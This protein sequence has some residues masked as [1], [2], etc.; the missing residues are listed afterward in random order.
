MLRTE[1]RNGGFQ[2]TLQVDEQF[3]LLP[4]H[5]PGNPILPGMCMVQAVLL[6]AAAAM[7][8]ND[9]RLCT[10]KNA[11]LVQPV[12]PGDAVVIDADMRRDADGQIAIKAKLSSNGERRAEISLTARTIPPDSGAQQL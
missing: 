12:F 5:F 4:D 7:G 3:V 11:K 2:A 10:V 6:A 9:L 1:S 8:E